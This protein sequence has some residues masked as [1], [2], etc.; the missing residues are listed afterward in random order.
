MDRCSSLE[1]IQE[2]S[3]TQ[4]TPAKRVFMKF[5][6]EVD[7]VCVELTKSIKHCY[8]FVSPNDE[9]AQEAKASE[10]KC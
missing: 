2:K 9:C 4:D 8:L 6:E 10:K 1:S 5:G 7:P 3:P